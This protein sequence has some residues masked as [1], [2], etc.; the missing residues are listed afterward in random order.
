MALGAPEQIHGD[1]MIDGWLDIYALGRIPFQM[2]ASWLPFEGSNAIE[3]FDLHLEDPQPRP[4]A[5]V[6]DCLRISLTW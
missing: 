5:L 4:D 2:V 6:R 1:D 3:V